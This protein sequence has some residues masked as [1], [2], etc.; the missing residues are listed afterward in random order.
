MKKLLL[1]AVALLALTGCD[2]D[3]DKAIKAAEAKITA[4]TDNIAGITFSDMEYHPAENGFS[5]IFGKYRTDQKRETRFVLVVDKNFK[6]EEPITVEDHRHPGV[7]D[8][9]WEDPCN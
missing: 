9:V 7:Q 2:S 4:M 3:K 5:C 8:F 1:L 6:V